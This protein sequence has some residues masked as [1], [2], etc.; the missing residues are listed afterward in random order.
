MR[1]YDVRHTFVEFTVYHFHL[2][3]HCDVVQNCILCAGTFVLLIRV[4]SREL[5]MVF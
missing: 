5:L 4:V 1:L 2:E 3:R